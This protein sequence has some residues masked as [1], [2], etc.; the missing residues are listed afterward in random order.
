MLGVIFLFKYFLG[1]VIF[2]FL[3]L[4]VSFFVKLG[5]E[6]FEEVLFFLL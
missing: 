1:K 6:M 4:L 2:I 3:M 5:I